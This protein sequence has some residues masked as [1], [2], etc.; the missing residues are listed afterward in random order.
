MRPSI[1]A[2]LLV[3]LSATSTLADTYLRP[4]YFTNWAHYRP[5]RGKYVPEDYIPGLCTH[6][7]FAFGWIDAQTFKARAYD[8]Q[9]LPSDWAG[10]GMYKRVNQLKQSDPGLKTLLSFGGWTFGTDIF[11][12]LAAERQHRQTFIS[13]A[14]EF[15]EKW[16]FDGI[17][18]DWEYPTAAD[19]DNYLAFVSELKEAILERSR[20]TGGDKHLLTAAVTPNVQKIDEG[21]HVAELSRHFD[22]ILLMSYDFHGAWEKKT[23]IQAPLYAKEGDT[24]SLEV[25]A[26]SWA[27]RGMPKKMIAIGIPTYGRGWTLNNPSDSEVGAPAS[28]PAQDLQYTRE[29]GVG[30]FYEFCDMLKAGPERR[31][32]DE[33]KTPYLVKNN[34][35]F[36][37]DDEESIGIKVDWLIENGFGGAF[38]WTL[39]N[40]DFNGKCAG[41][42]YPLHSVI[43]KK[44][45]GNDISPQSP[46]TM[47]P[48]V[49]SATGGTIKPIGIFCDGQPDG[50][51]SHPSSCTSFL[52][53]LKSQAYE[54]QCPSD[55]EFSGS[56]GYCT[57]S[58]E[59]NCGKPES[60]SVTVRPPSRQ[61]TK[62]PF[63]CREDG[64]FPDPESCFRF[65][66]CA[67]GIAYQFDCAGGL[68][69]N[70]K[71][72]QCDHPIAA[73]CNL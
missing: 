44:L 61:T 64:F 53:C 16:G 3:G 13:S 21:Y 22:F 62:G 56:L 66:R 23:G 30:A 72:G 24:F 59:A 9:D 6:I 11:K 42:R 31:W 15:I 14:I 12:R 57:S 67:N 28:S 29:A 37:Y 52:L 38:T 55:L 17:D 1:L 49:I 27:E 60:P 48:S 51:Q 8:D 58:K 26:N 19:K 70:A 32:D 63:V 71:T 45:T 5:G 69:F 47:A 73:N 10:P 25:A 20:Q 41:K 4:C 65:Y 36:S 40:D 39:D 68:H 2:V 43:V 54:L 7:L 50:F 34:Q 35:W 33:S 46:S 18:I